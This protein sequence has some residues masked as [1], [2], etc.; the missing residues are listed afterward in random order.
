[1]TLQNDKSN[2]H[3]LSPI[4]AM[5]D[6]ALVKKMSIGYDELSSVLSY[7]SETGWFTW[8]TTVST[9]T[10]AGSPAGTWLT[11]KNGKKYLSITYQGRKMSASQVAW[12]LYYKEWPGRSIHFV[13][14]DTEN[15]RISN[16]KKAAYLSTRVI[17]AG[18][19]TRY[20]M[21]KEQARH[22]GLAR[23][24]SVTMTQ[25]AEM[26]AAQNGCCAICMRPETARL[27]GRKTGETESRTRDLSVDHDHETNVVRQL[28]CNA[29]NHMLGH[30]AD[31]AGRLR[32]AANYID[33]HRKALKN[34][35]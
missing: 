8:L 7:A 33:F 30:A 24:Y 19:I 12:L 31:D 16:L 25:Y 9:T 5:E 10:P 26:F 34:V 17:D 27:P 18:G 15:L 2:I 32:A 20:R 28:L 35:S 11:A 21:S 4:T 1:M 22:Y 6:D 29:C 23:N 13:D 14:E 3:Y